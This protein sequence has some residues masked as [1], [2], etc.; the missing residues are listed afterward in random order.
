MDYPTK[1]LDYEQKEERERTF[2][3]KMR[4]AFIKTLE[5]LTCRSN[6]KF[7]QEEVFG[8]KSILKKCIH[9]KDNLMMN[10]LL[11]LMNLTTEASIEACGDSLD[12]LVNMI[13][14]VNTK[15]IALFDNAFVKNKACYRIHNIRWYEKNKKINQIVLKRESSHIDKEMIIQ[16]NLELTNLT[17]DSRSNVT[18]V[19]VKM[20]KTDWVNQNGTLNDLLTV[21]SEAKD[22][23]FKTDL[24]KTL[25][26]GFWDDLSFAIKITCLYPFLC[27][28]LTNLGYLTFF[29]SYSKEELTENELMFERASRFTLIFFQLYYIVIWLC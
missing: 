29:L 15:V 8:Y 6:L 21:L 25:L 1:D 14:N 27:F 7:R 19:D 13:K 22:E 16:R 2:R 23:L 26:G 10:Y 11:P 24:F 5:T 18:N 4:T 9:E 20:L 3:E 17:D 28:T 12:D